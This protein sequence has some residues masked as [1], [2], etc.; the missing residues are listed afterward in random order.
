MSNIIRIFPGQGMIKEGGGVSGHLV[1]NSEASTGLANQDTWYTWNASDWVT[2]DLNDVT[3]TNKTLVIGGT[4]PKDL[5]VSFSGGLRTSSNGYYELAIMK[6]GLPILEKT[7]YRGRV[8]ATSTAHSF[9]SHA[10]VNPGDT[11]AVGVWQDLGSSITFY[12]EELS[13]LSIGSM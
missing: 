13:R 2:D 12:F 8:T 9:I 10:S 6:N 1:V 7:I 5:L 3:R 4:H 11:I